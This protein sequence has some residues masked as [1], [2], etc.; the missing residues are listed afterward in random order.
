MGDTSNPWF[1]SHSGTSFGAGRPWFHLN[2]RYRNP[3]R[4][5]AHRC[6]GSL[7]IAAIKGIKFATLRHIVRESVLHLWHVL[8]IL[9]SALVF[10]YLLTTP[11]LCLK[12]LVGWIA[13]LRFF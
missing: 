9:S 7:L 3:H 1:W 12:N 2:F 11:A 4:N 8:A 13:E 5:S 6:V 10:G